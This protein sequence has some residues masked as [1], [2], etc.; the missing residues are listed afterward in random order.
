MGCV[1]KPFGGGLVALGTAPAA[2]VDDCARVVVTKRAAPSQCAATVIN[3]DALRHGGALA[4]RR[5]V[6]AW[7]VTATR[8]R[9]EAR[10]WEAS[11]AGGRA[12]I[13]APAAGPAARQTRRLGPKILA[14][15]L[16]A[17]GVRIQLRSTSQYVPAARRAAHSFVAPA[18]VSSPTRTR[19]APIM[20]MIPRMTTFGSR[21]ATIA[22]YFDRHSR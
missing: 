1:A 9:G 21:S 19:A 12:R 11:G 15:R 7:D 13:A 20:P 14:P 4:L 18:R 3:R 5:I 2:F 16:R 10:P 8:L 22:A 17:A 6:Y